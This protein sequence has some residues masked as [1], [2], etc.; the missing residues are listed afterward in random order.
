MQRPLPISSGDGKRWAIERHARI[1]SFPWLAAPNAVWVSDF[2]ALPVIL[3]FPSKRRDPRCLSDWSS[4][5]CSSD[6]NIAGVVRGHAV[7]SI[8]ARL[9]AGTIHT[10]GHSGLTRQSRYHASRCDLANGIVA[11]VCHKDIARVVRCD[12]PRVPE[13]RI[14]AGAILAAGMARQSG[15][16]AHGAFGCDLPNGIVGHIRHKNIA[17]AVH[18]NAEGSPEPRFTARAVGAAVASSN[19][20]E[21]AYDSARRNLSDRVVAGVRHVNTAGTVHRDIVGQ[22]KLSLVSGAISVAADA[23]LSGQCGDVQRRLA[24]NGRRWNG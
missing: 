11:Q 6:I 19:S 24:S 5:V 4:D 14:G 9:A 15:Q 20:S 23:N 2:S 22:P 3:V 1:R 7:G 17:S 8:K 12:T 16:S 10:A 18:R 13:P 21:S